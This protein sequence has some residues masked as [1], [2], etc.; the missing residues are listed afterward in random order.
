MNTTR[1]LIAACAAAGILLSPTISFAV[2]EQ[3]LK[4]IQQQIKA[5]KND[6]EAKIKSLE[7]RL[8]AAEQTAKAAEIKA[9]ATPATIATA[10][11]ASP[12]ASPPPAQPSV[13]AAAGAFNPAI[14]AVLTG[15]YGQFSK[16]PDNAKIPGFE[17]GPGASPGTR[18]FSL[19]ESEIDLTANIDQALYGSLVLSFHPDDTVGVE[20]GFI[21]TTSLPWGF[22]VKAGRFFS[23]IGYLNQNHAHAWDFVDSPLPYRALLN[24]QYGDDGVQVRW[25]AP[26]DWFLEFGAEA[27]RGDAFP[28]ANG[29][30]HGKG[31]GSL[32]V[33]A[34]ND[35]NES[36]SWLAGLSYL[37]TRAGDRVSGG[38]TFNGRDYIGIAS[39]VYKWAP[40]GNPTQRNLILNGEFF[41][42]Q[43]QGTFNGS[44]LDQWRDG[45]YV[46]GVYQFMPR[47]RVGFR[48]DELDSEQLEGAFA[49]GTLDNLGHTPRRNTA[50]LEYD[51][52][53]FARFRLQYMRD[54]A[55]IATDDEVLLTYNVTYGPHGA[56][57][58]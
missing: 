3:E 41:Y 26:T 7:A 35:I 5:L 58:F 23:G 53:E 54:D 38:D 46:Q 19:D 25:L 11:A 52:S 12:P 24:T 2:S 1:F 22:T 33:H 28:A 37:Q 30:G 43:E 34:G 42:G 17:L 39:L 8:Q 40:E 6:Y 10:A 56:H 57:R 4:D 48:H 47:W 18:G 36:S 9:S 44:H 51:T 49:G 15:S 16:N 27:F 55:D 13:P 20:E 21:Q 29:P 50:L 45:W 32:F 14:S 31:A